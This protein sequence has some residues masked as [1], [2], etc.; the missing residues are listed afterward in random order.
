MRSEYQSSFQLVPRRPI[1]LSLAIPCFNYPEG[2]ENIISKASLSTK[3]KLELVI[4]DDSTN[5]EVEEVSKTSSGSIDITYIRGPAQRTSHVD[6]WNACLSCCKGDYL[7]LMH[8]DDCPQSPSFFNDLTEEIVKYNYPDVIILQPKITLGRHPVAVYPL[9]LRRMLFA[10]LGPASL[11]HF[12]YIGPPSVVAYR[13]DKFNVKYLSSLQFLVD[14]EFYIRLLSQPGIS[15]HWSQLAIL[16]ETSRPNQVTNILK[17][18]KIL[19][20]LLKTERRA[21]KQYSPFLA[22]PISQIITLYILY[23][24]MKLRI[25]CFRV[26]LT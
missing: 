18:N 6:N 15:I 7:I 9:Q 10:L 19:I 13:R 22:L 8:H 11:L 21:I 5:N 17:Q 12:N 25:F 14:I 23:F 26:A 4:S 24:I 2:L 1:F 3:G 16:T 20:N